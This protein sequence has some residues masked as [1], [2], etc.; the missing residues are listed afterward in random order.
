MHMASL[1]ES[2][3]FAFLRPLFGNVVHG[4]GWCHGKG[5]LFDVFVFYYFLICLCMCVV[6]I[7]FIYLFM[8][9]DGFPGF[10][11]FCS[12]FGFFELIL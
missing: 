8:V 6:F 1:G 5:W 11:G 4:K 10:S 7:D 3:D 9:L 12:C 2:L